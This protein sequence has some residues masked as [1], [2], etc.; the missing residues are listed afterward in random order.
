[1]KKVWLSK[2]VWIAAIALAAAIAQIIADREVIDANAQVAGLAFIAFV[3][4]LLTKD[5]VSW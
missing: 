2:T 3:L 1:M 4:R 5:A